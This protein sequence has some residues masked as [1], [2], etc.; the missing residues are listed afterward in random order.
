MVMKAGA[1]AAVAAEGVGEEQASPSLLLSH[2]HDV[3]E[4]V[5]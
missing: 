1:T 2:G 5:A 3:A 4:V